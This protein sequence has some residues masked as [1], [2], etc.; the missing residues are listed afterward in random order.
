MKIQ[1]KFKYS[2]GDLDYLEICTL[3][4]EEFLTALNRIELYEKMSLYGESSAEIYQELQ[5]LY[6]DYC[7]IGGYPGVVLKYLGNAPL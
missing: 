3:G 2:S 7:M 1:R 5:K 6:N 4:F